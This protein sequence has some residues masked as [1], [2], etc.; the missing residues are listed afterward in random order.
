[1]ALAVGLAPAHANELLEQWR[2]TAVPAIQVVAIKLYTGIPGVDGTQNASGNTSRKAVTFAAASAGSMSANGTL[3]SWTSWPVGQNGEVIS[4]VGFFA[5]TALA[6]S[7]GTFKRSAALA[8][9]LTM[10]TGGTLTITAITFAYA[11]IA[12]T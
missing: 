1:M 4:H 6:D 12:S 9:T 7:G 11:P 2:N 5:M 10:S 3:P 8:S